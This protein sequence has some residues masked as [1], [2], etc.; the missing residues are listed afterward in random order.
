MPATNCSSGVWMV[1]RSNRRASNLLARLFVGDFLGGPCLDASGLLLAAGCLTF[2][3][4]ARLFVAKNYS[5]A[6]DRTD[7][8]ETG[9]A[10]RGNFAWGFAT[11]NVEVHHELLVVLTA[12]TFHEV[13]VTLACGLRVEHG[14]LGLGALLGLRFTLRLRFGFRFCLSRW[15]LLGCGR[16]GQHLRRGLTSFFA[17]AQF[18]DCLDT[19]PAELLLQPINRRVLLGSPSC[20]VRLFGAYLFFLLCQRATTPP[21]TPM[22]KSRQGEGSDPKVS[23]VLG[24][25]TP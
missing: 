13:G 6:I 24:G 8:F 3:Y 23:A 21:N 1:R 4:A 10:E 14:F 12:P 9:R 18:V 7:T 5:V 17:L 16:L 20:D 2:V 19:G 25:S 15:F 22:V 11:V